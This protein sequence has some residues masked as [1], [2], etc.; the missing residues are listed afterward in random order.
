MSDENAP[1]WGGV[2]FEGD[3]GSWVGSFGALIIQLFRNRTDPPY[4]SAVVT[5]NTGY[6]YENDDRE[7]E[8]IG[9]TGCTAEEA[10]LASLRDYLSKGRIMEKELSDALAG[11]R[12][13]C[14][15]AELLLRFA[16]R[17]EGSHA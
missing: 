17:Q 9:D 6:A 7:L 10:I 2:T 3:D 1:V 11:Q 15:Q 8:G 4:W 14:G 5:R 13:C 12:L 16:P